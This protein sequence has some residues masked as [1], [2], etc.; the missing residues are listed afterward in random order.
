MTTNSPGCGLL[1]PDSEV[2]HVV[3]AV[4]EGA[5]VTNSP[6]QLKI[7]FDK[8]PVLFNLIKE[9]EGNELPEEVKNLLKPIKAKALAP[10]ANAVNMNTQSFDEEQGDML[11]CFPNM[12]RYR[13]RPVFAADLQRSERT[14]KKR[15]GRQ[16]SLLPGIF[17]LFCTH[18]DYRYYYM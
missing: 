1:H 18:S 8:I 10:F 12:P 17:T 9:L 13:N 14:C 15:A 16:P 11:S 6:E 3:D 4:L 7:L 2:L 5:S